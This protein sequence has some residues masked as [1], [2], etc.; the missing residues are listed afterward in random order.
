MAATRSLHTTLPS[1]QMGSKARAVSLRTDRWCSQ[2]LCEGLVG[3][4]LQSVVE[5]VPP[6]RGKPSHHGQ[7]GGVSRNVH[8]DLSAPQPELTVWM[9]MVHGKPRVA[10]AVQHVPK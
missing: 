5:V 4:P 6:N 9:V 8:M 2:K 3:S 7:V 1:F 10:E